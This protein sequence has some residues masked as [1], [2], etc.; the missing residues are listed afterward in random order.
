MKRRSFLKYS[1]AFALMNAA[2]SLFA[3]GKTPFTIYGAPALPS[4]TIAVAGLQGQ[5][6]KQTDFA[7]KIWRTPD[8]LRAGVASGEFKVMM[9]PS[10]VGVNLRN[11]KQN[12]GMINILTN[13]ITQMV[14]KKPLNELGSLVGKKLIMPF[15]ND[16]PDIV[17]KALFKQLNIDESKIEI[18]YTATP[19]EAVELF[20]AKDFDAAF[21]P[22]PLTSACILKGKKAGIEVVRSF[23]TAEVWA[24]AFNTK[25]IIPQAG[26]IANV[27]FFK[28]NQEH[29][30][31]LHQDL[32]QAL[33]WV[34]ANPK[35]A[36]DIG[37]N[38]F[39]APA[40]SI[41][42]AIPNAR[43]SVTKGSEI[44]QEILQFYEIL[45]R[46]NP[47]LLGGKM[48]DEHFFLC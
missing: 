35:E 31:L 1:S 17:L 25:P 46:Y 42:M 32:T 3:A 13:G 22:E 29:F 8:Q 9:S 47:K 7:L 12:V 18:T 36:A 23:D 44:K 26:I 10:N 43:L 2:P 41:A 40:P 5:L 11:Q 28:A 48:P 6:A 39:P 24:N 21:L 20:I 45:M 16:M 37:A 4:L 15:K 14:S 27:D 38:Y 19:A 34:K 33:A 30:E